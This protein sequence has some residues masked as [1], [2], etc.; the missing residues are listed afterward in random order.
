MHP[1]SHGRAPTSW[2][3]AAVRLVTDTFLSL[4]DEAA[5]GLVEGLYLHGSL[6]F[7][8]WY[9]ARSDID[10][11][12]VLARR[13]DDRQVDV[14]RDVHAGVAETFP[15]PPFDGFHLIWDDLARSPYA[16]PDVPCT[17]GGYFHEE[18]RLDVQPVTWHEVV[19]HGLTVRGPEPG[20]LGIWTDEQVLREYTHD[21]LRSYW[22]AEVDQ[23]R[24]FPDEAARPDIVAWFVLG[25]SRLHHLLAT[26]RLTSKTGAGRYA[27]ERFGERWRPIVAEAIVYRELDESTGRYDGEPA[28]RAEDTIDFVDMV[29]ASG[30]A[31]PV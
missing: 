12:A 3:P 1:G 24:K 29:V 14:L 10:Y 21:N 26:G 30:L 11:V 22:A 15:R 9:D 25:V 8:E 17:Q 31:I 18:A 16:C 23:L 19:H 20:T 4:A 5:P 6:G 13:P 28:R 7:G 2:P 27:L